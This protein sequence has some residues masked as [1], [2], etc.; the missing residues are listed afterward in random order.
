MVGAGYRGN[1][2]FLKYFYDSV[3]S[4]QILDAG[5]SFCRLSV[6]SLSGSMRESLR[7]WRGRRGLLNTRSE[8]VAWTSGDSW[9]LKLLKTDTIKISFPRRLSDLNWI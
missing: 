4:F 9:P 5:L 3:D 8:Q 6:S 1:H 2:Y 7:S